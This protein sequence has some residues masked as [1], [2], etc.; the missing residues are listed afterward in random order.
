[1]SRSRSLSWRAACAGLVCGLVLASAPAS[2]TA[3]Y[4]AVYAFGDSLS[5]NGNLFA[6]TGGVP[7][8]PYFEG[9]FSNGKA[10]IEY[11]AQGLGV[12]LFDL[13]VGGATTGLYNAN[14]PLYQVPLSNTGVLSQLGAFTTALGGHA[15]DSQALYSV[16]AGAN[17][18]LHLGTLS[19]ELT[20]SIAVSNLAQ[21]VTGLYGLGARNFL[22]PLMPDLG[23]TPRLLAGG[24][25]VS[26]DDA[27][28]LSFGFNQALGGVYAGLAALPDI[29]LT[30]FDTFAAQHAITAHPGDFGLS[31]TTEA[32][33]SGSVGVPGTV[34]ATPS[35]Y[36]Y[37]DDIHP[38]ARVH[39]LLG[40][41]MLAQ[42]VP[43]P[44]TLLLMS[45]GLVLLLAQGR[46]RAG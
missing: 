40:G 42:V 39:Q 15:A 10:A 16:W 34:C 18:F 45:A 44:Q 28:L 8:P 11:V 27:S 43:E 1:M 7:Q 20:V 38:S 29:H 12:A 36:F 19:A 33:F 9:R 26:A 13:A 31:N 14:F 32:C 21:T 6:L 35:T 22:L 37:W 46:R 30:V 17:D 25:P 41:Q 5:D 24:G 23:L 3:P 2:A 4:S